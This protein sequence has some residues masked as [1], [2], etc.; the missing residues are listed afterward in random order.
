VIRPRLGLFVLATVAL[1]C[2]RLFAWDLFGH[3]VVGAIA[4][5]N[6]DEATRRAASDLL[7][8]APEDSDLPA[9][10]PLDPRPFSARGREHFV[11]AAGWADLVRDEVWSE[12]KERYDHPTWHFVNRFWTPT[13]SG[14]KRLPEKGTLGELVVRL[15][16]SRTRVQDLSLAAS[17]R[18]IALAWI[19]HLA[20]DIH[21]PLHSSGRVTAR[22]PEGDRGGNDFLLDDLESPNLHALW[23]MILSRSRR[24][25]YSESYFH[26]VDRVAREIETLHPEESLEPDLKNRSFEDWSEAGAAI[27]MKS[28]YPDH[29]SRDGAPPPSYEAD[30][31]ASAA[32]QVALAGHRL[33]RL[34]ED[35]FKAGSESPPD[36][37]PHE[38]PQLRR[39]RHEALPL[40]LDGRSR[41]RRFWSMLPPCRSS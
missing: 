21:Q 40:L 36:L 6:M 7:L 4:W 8:Q 22:D 30:V 19:L 32:R 34:I 5:E 15:G 31:F 17:D 41:I 38:V 39:G 11:T 28:A 18:A 29:L 26:R 25:R 3:H 23:D 2:E 1:D 37:P 33:A 35:S 10:L 27:A 24:Q 12:R 16:E 20:G 9:L 13:A 14:P